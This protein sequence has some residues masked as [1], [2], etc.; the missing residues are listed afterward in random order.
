VSRLIY[1]ILREFYHEAAGRPLRTGTFRAIS[2]AAMGAGSCGV[3]H[4]FT[5]ST[6]KEAKEAR[7]DGGS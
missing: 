3:V 7:K 1:E 5:I 6:T 4:I 2:E